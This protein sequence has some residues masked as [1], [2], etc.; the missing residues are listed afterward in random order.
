MRMLHELSQHDDSVFITLT[1][2]EETLPN[3]AS[4]KK[5]DLQKFFKRIRKELAK[6]G[7]NI[8]YF[9]CGEYG[10]TFGRPHYHAIVFGLS[11]R[12]DDKNLVSYKWPFGHVHY[13][14]AEVDSIR[15]VAQYI[16]KKYSGD[17]AQQ[18]YSDK[19][20]DPVFRISSL[21]LG[22][23]YL[24]QH[25]EQIRKMGKCTVKG[26]VHSLPRYYIHKLGIDTEVLK[27]AAQ[28]QAAE[29]YEKHTGLNLD[30]DIAYKVRPAAEITQYQKAKADQRKQKEIDLSAKVALK[31][32]KL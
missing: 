19:G 14:L 26:V 4:L 30:P 15:Y 18:E 10:D 32:K 6:S 13:G 11:L 28:I 9:A 3:N 8:R 29:D 17:L 25:G 20:R 27:Q 2:S 16:D 24:E 31:R 5:S 23:T 12:P 7:R 22:K 21:G 1:Y